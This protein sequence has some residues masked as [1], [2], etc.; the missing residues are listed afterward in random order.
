MG[1]FIYWWVGGWVG[2]WVGLP[3]WRKGLGPM[4][5]T[6]TTRPRTTPMSA[7]RYCWAVSSR[8]KAYRIRT[9]VNCFWGGWVVEKIE[10]NEAGI[11][12]RCWSPWV[13]EKVE[14]EKV[15]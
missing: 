4:V 13:V 7:H 11:G 14:E 2:G 9:L 3:L 10:E 6:R 5:G 12:M 8:T 1:G 15:V